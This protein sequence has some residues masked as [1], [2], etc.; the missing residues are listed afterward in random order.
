M[1]MQRGDPCDLTLL[2]TGASTAK[3]TYRIRLIA[4][5]ATD[6]SPSSPSSLA[7]LW[8]PLCDLQINSSVK[9]THIIGPT[10]TNCMIVHGSLGMFLTKV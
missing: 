8:G 9:C 2:V 1:R 5:I 3:P 4:L 10:L 6:S 7:D